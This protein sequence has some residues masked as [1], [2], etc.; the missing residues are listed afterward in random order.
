MAGLAIPGMSHFIATPL[1]ER[2]EAERERPFFSGAP[3]RYALAFGKREPK[4]R[5]RKHARGLIPYSAE[6]QA[7][8][9]HLG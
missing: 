4:Q 6:A 3:L 7:Q 9:G 1:P 8:M 2:S 5:F